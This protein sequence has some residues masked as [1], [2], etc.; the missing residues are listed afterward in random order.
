M[1]SGV[2]TGLRP[3]AYCACLPPGRRLAVRSG[4]GIRVSH[5]LPPTVLAL[6]ADDTVDGLPTL[7]VRGEL[8][9]GSATALRR[10]LQA[11]TAGST[12]SAIV[13]LAGVTFM[14]AAAL[15]TICD[16]QER[17]LERGEGLTVV[18]RHPQLLALFKVVEIERVLDVVPT[19]AAARRRLR[20]ERPSEHLSGWIA[21]RQRDVPPPEAS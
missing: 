2:Q 15:H 16:E 1:R 18:T 8:D 9:V 10:W 17:L 11:T 4:A 7:S 3:T 20:S 13:D 21:R 5:I 19:R 14:A 12:R 6:L